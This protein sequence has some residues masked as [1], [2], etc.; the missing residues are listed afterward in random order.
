[1]KSHR[2]CCWT[3][4][5]VS[6]IGRN[7]L[8]MVAIS[9][10]GLASAAQ[11]PSPPAVTPAPQVLGET[12]FP[13]YSVERVHEFWD[14]HL[15]KIIMGE[16]V[17]GTYPINPIDARY[18]VLFDETVKRYGRP[19]N[20]RAST[21]RVNSPEIIPSG[22]FMKGGVPFVW[23]SVPA[24]MDV[25]S[26]LQHSGG[27]HWEKQFEAFVVISVLHEM[28]H[29]AIGEVGSPSDTREELIDRE[30]KA[31]AETA[32]NTLPIFVKNNFP[33]DPSDTSY[34]KAWVSC[35]REE[36]ACWKSFIEGG[37]ASISQRYKQIR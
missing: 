17:R 32:E 7:A 18:K 14:L 8:L 26:T 1:M 22:C 10:C 36:N 9:S 28:D 23:I 35:G 20:I 4:F 15:N 30:T 29:I 2:G 6:A 21:Q 3:K 5:R 31:W 24:M 19:F 34:Y 33:M 37:Y 12:P 16:L 13:Q 11:Q 25:Y 27:P